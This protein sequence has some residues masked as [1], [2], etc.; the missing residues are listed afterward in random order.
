M[1]QELQEE[2]HEYSL[3]RPKENRDI[4]GSTD[5]LVQEDTEECSVTGQMSLSPD[6]S[7]PHTPRSVGQFTCNKETI[8]FGTIA[9]IFVLLI[10]LCCTAITSMVEIA[11]LKSLVNSTIFI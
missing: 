10:A 5:K 6:D 1:E 7:S 11:K 4:T 9:V 8:L 2:P 3:V